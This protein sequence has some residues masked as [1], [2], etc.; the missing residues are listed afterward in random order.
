MDQRH[1]LKEGRQGI[2]PKTGH[3]ESNEQA[4]PYH[5]TMVE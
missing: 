1:N 3:L 2:Q 4:Q 5:T